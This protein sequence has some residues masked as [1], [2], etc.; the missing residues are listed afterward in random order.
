MSNQ[1][2]EDR[3]INITWCHPYSLSE[4][5]V[6][7]AIFLVNIM[8]GRFKYF[9]RCLLQV[10]SPLITVQQHELERGNLSNVEEWGQLP[11][12]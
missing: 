4:D 7:V 1:T 8:I 11:R 3:P 12:W 9:L 10:L 5:I 2:F 6:P